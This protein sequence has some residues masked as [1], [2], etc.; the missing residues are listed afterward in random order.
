M[1]RAADGHDIERAE[2]RSDVLEPA[3]D[4]SYRDAGAVRRRARRLDHARLRVDADDLPAIGP[5][6]DREDARPGADIEQA[7]AAVEPE[8]FGGGGEKRRSVRRSRA[9]VIGDGGGEASHASTMS[10]V[11]GLR[12]AA[13]V[14]KKRPAKKRRLLKGLPRPAGIP[15]CRRPFIF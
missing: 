4:K 6:A 5:E 9:L 14:F 7:L 2:L 1:D 13:P 15:S 12:V 11:Q 10:A 3:L 8:L